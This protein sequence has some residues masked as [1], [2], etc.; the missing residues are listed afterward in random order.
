MINKV[1]DIFVVQIQGFLKTT[2]HQLQEQWK[3]YRIYLAKPWLGKNKINADR[4]EVDLAVSDV[5]T[6]YR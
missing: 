2:D 3:K 5:M 4:T 6:L 1:T